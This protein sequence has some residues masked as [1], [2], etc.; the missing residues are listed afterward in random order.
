MPGS[1]WA[2]QRSGEAHPSGAP[3]PYCTRTGLWGA[4]WPVGSGFKSPHRAPYGVVSS[5][6]ARNG[7][8]SV[9]KSV[10]RRADA[11]QRWAPLTGSRGPRR[12][13]PSTRRQT[14]PSTAFGKFIVGR[15][16]GG[17]CWGGFTVA[18]RGGRVPAASRP[19]AGAA[20]LPSRRARGPA[21]AGRGRKAARGRRRRR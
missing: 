10:A 18:G 20:L 9:S 19:G 13:F 6:L 16:L 1:R 12:P 15:L 4:D 11:G 14:A 17:R 3:A 21:W 5:F 2:F 8:K 7:Y